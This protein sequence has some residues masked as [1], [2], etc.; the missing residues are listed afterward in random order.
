MVLTLKPARPQGFKVGT[1]IM[2]ITHTWI[3]EE[4]G[5]EEAW[6]VMSRREHAAWRRYGGEPLEHC[7]PPRGWDWSDDDDD[8]DDSGQPGHYLV[9]SGR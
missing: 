2:R 6:A 3:N 8:T 9:R 7:T 5:Q 1:K 4:T